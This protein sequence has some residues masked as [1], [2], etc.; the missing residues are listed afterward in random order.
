L[1]STPPRIAAWLAAWLAGQLGWKPH[2]RPGS[3]TSSSETALHAEFLAPQ[4]TIAV[5]ITTR[6]DQ[7]ASTREP[8]VMGVTL[9]AKGREGH[10]AERFS[11]ARPTINATAVRVDAESGDLCRLPRLVEAPELEPARRVAAALESSRIDPPVQNALPNALWLLEH[12]G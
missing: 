9:T 2:G 3:T 10:G 8:R 12:A 11:L 6:P 1:R 5:R 7:T 4:G